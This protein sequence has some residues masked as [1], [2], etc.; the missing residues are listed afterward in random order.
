MRPSFIVV[1]DIDFTAFDQ[2]FIEFGMGYSVKILGPL[3]RF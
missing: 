2:L 1:D 3:S